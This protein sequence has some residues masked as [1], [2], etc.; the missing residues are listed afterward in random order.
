MRQFRHKKLAHNNIHNRP[1]LVSRFWKLENF[2]QSHPQSLL[3]SVIA[4]IS[5]P[6]QDWTKKVSKREMI[7]DDEPK[8]KSNQISALEK[9][10]PAQW[11]LSLFL[12]KWSRHR[13]TCSIIIMGSSRAPERPRMYINVKYV[14]RSLEAESVYVAM[15]RHT[16]YCITLWWLSPDTFIFSEPQRGY[17][18]LIFKYSPRV[19]VCLCVVSCRVGV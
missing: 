16:I 8:S 11:L 14:Y 10:H 12:T 2:C 4:G 19:R 13:P 17:R 6:L 18:A 5:V 3:I 15:Q 1:I 9:V 7:D